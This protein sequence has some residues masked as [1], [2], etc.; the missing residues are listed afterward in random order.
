MKNFS[1]QFATLKTANCLSLLICLPFVLSAQLSVT[2]SPTN[3]TCFGAANGKAQA[4]PVGGTPPYTY[5]W[6]NTATTKTIQNLAPG[7]YFVT[8]SD[9]NQNTKA[10]ANN[11]TQ[12]QL[13]GLTAF[14]QSQLCDVAP[15]GMAAV[16]PFGGTPAYT[17]LWSNGGT[18]AQINNLIGGIYNV[19][20][21]DANSCTVSSFYQ[22]GYWAEGLW[23]M[24]NSTPTSC[25]F[26]IGSAQVFPGSGIAPYQYEWSNGATT[27]E[28]E[29][30]GAGTYTVTVSDANACSNSAEAI[31]ISNNAFISLSIQTSTPYCLNAI[32][33][34]Q[35]EPPPAL[36]PQ[37]L[38]TLNN[39][40]DT[41]ISGQGTDSIQIKWGT[42]GAKTVKY[43]F[44]ANGVYCSSTTYFLKVA[45]C[46]DANEPKLA[47]AIVSPNPFSDLLLIDFPDGK[48]ADTEAILTDVF[49]KVL[50]EKILSA[51][52]EVLLTADLPS[53]LYL[54]KIKSEY[55]ERVWKL[56][57]N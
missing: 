53:A 39:P 49:G 47:A 13:L 46:A 33:N 22:V 2:I 4:N 31:I 37:I 6:S 18:T 20:L 14:G 19:T 34:F 26:E 25:A 41:I 29:N 27:A 44:G 36:Y 45:V 21:T 32:A 43:Q 10:A 30:L 42:V 12:P 9:A 51:T 54:L 16:V 40:A 3:I 23:L 11:I 17:Y 28:I 57:K 52:T 24:T 8:V 56:V 15:D 48:P 50:V 38:W 5:V 7:N 55:G 35:R 1:C